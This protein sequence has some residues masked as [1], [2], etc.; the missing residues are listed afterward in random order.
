MAVGRLKELCEKL[1]EK[2]HYPIATPVAIVE[3]AGCPDQRTVRGTLKTIAQIALDFKIKAPS[4]I[5]VGDVVNVLQ[6]E[7]LVGLVDC[8]NKSQSA[9]L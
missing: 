3:K 6:E 1:V 7:S 8:E 5:I 4:T 9:I 2:A